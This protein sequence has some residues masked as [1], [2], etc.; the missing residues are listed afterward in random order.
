MYLTK[1]KHHTSHMEMFRKCFYPVGQESYFWDTVI[2][3]N[4]FHKIWVWGKLRIWMDCLFPKHMKKHRNRDTASL[5]SS[6]NK[7]ILV[8]CLLP[9]I[10]TG[11]IYTMHVF[12]SFFACCFLGSFKTKQTKTDLKHKELFVFKLSSPHATVTLQ[13]S[14]H[15]KWSYA[16]DNIYLVTAGRT[17]LY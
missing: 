2:I 6:R 5:S 11:S 1:S 16:R 14:F 8:F 4:L 3:L 9:M 10:L 13:I 17:K 15:F 12:V 7:H